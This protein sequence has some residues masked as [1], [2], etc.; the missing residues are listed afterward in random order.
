[1]E[2]IVAD[3]TAKFYAIDEAMVPEGFPTHKHS[4]EFWEELGRCVATYGF[5][6]ETL[7]KAIFS[8]TATTEVDEG[9]L[10]AAYKAW[11]PKLQKALSDALGNL[12]ANYA[13]AVRDHQ[14][15]E[16]ENFKDLIK[17][18]RQMAVIRNVISHGSWGVP[19]SSGRSLPF[20]VNNKDEVWQIPIDVAYLKHVQAVTA[21]L[22]IEVIN[23]VTVHGWQFPGSGGPGKP[24][25][26]HS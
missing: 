14:S 20:F 25:W 5:L 6:E 11:L 23:T 18:L 16:P 8:F 22:T 2:S 12:I 15:V 24:I 7:G 17:D 13:K 21:R 9:D 1:M 10:E 3:E 4:P 19:D 26:P